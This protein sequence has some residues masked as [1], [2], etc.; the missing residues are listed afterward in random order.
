[1]MKSKRL[2]LPLVAV[3]SA[4][5]AACVRATPPPGTPTQGMGAIKPEASE[6]LEVCL[7]RVL[8][9]AQTFANYLTSQNLAAWSPGGHTLAYVST[10]DH[11]AETPVELHFTPGTPFNT[12]ELQASGEVNNL[13][14]SP[15]GSRLALSV[16]RGEDQ[17][18][19]ILVAGEDGSDI[20]DLMPGGAAQ[21]GT[22][23]ATKHIK[24]WWD[25]SRLLILAHCGT[26]C[27]RPFLLDLRDGK[28]TPFFELGRE[29]E[30]LG[31]GYTWSPDKKWVVVLSGASP[32]LGIA[33]GEGGEITWLSGRRAANPDWE[34]FFTFSPS[35][36]PDSSRFAFLRQP[37]D[38]SRPPELWVWEVQSDQALHLLDGVASAVWSPL[39][40][41]GIAVLTLGQPNPAPEGSW[42]G[43]SASPDGPNALRMGVYSINSKKMVAFEDL[44]EIALGYR[45]PD[46]FLTQ[47][48]PP[49]WSP[50]GRRIAYRDAD[51]SPWVLSTGYGSANLEMDGELVTGFEWSPDGAMLAVKTENNVWVYS[52]PCPGND[53][54]E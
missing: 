2:A 16:L 24:S 23:V 52:V 41:D 40:E 5:L 27:S 9:T 29:G 1:M 15:D 19:T 7:Q 42:Q 50:D 49:L 3:L 38:T 32:Q 46:G 45:Q 12:L 14:W 54:P 28:Q 13:A 48:L 31:A 33:P 17:L 18:F 36:A 37:S 25:D 43:V 20:R 26:G 6:T 21:T 39:S 10:T 4:L 22:G 34:S 51:N 47:L 11:S 53:R 44:G 30:Y 8:P 35:W